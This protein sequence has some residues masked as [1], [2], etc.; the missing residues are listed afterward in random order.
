[1]GGENPECSAETD[2]NVERGRRDL[3]G[4]PSSFLT[5]LQKSATVGFGGTG[6][7]LS[8]V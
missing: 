3:L 5:C 4:G 1:M 7:M 6:K 2:S 8:N